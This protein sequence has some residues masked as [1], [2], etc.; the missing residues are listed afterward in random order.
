MC[1]LIFRKHLVQIFFTPGNPFSEQ[2]RLNYVRTNILSFRL[3]FCPIF[4][5]KLCFETLVGGWKMRGGGGHH[6]PLLF[7]W[8]DEAKATGRMWDNIIIFILIIIT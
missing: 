6:H 8:Q 3:K 4:V 5:K 1:R 2:E 7:S